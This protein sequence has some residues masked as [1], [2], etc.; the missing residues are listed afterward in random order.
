MKANN[1]TSTNGQT[2]PTL[3]NATA[4]SRPAD[5]SPSPPEHGTLPIDLRHERGPFDIVGDVHGCADELELLLGRLGYDVAR[6]GASD[7]PRYHVV[8]PPGRKLIFVGDLIDRGPRVADTLRLALDMI[9]AG[10]AFAVLGNHEFKAARMFAGHNVS[11]APGLRLTLQDLEYQSE[12]FRDRV[13]RFVATL[14]SH[15]V[16]DDGRLVVSHAGI[17]ED[18]IGRSSNAVRSF[19]IYGDTTGER[20]PDGFPVRRDWAAA[21]RGDALIA[22]GHTTV[23]RAEWCN[24]TINL[25]TACVFGGSLTALRYPEREIVSVAAARPYFGEARF[26]G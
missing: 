15:L 12:A 10:S 21:Y 11:I 20:G 26:G 16:L 1:K 14:P 18:M 2:T 7:E 24:G 4:A 13:R 6:A 3:P 22:Y 23:E 17:R 25:D 9:D 5:P 8:P 19:C